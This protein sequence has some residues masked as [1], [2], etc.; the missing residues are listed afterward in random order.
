MNKPLVMEL[1]NTSF[2][3]AVTTYVLILFFKM[4]DHAT[5]RNPGFISLGFA[6]GFIAMGLIRIKRMLNLDYDNS[7]I[8]TLQKKIAKTKVLVL[9]FRKTEYL[10]LP[11]YTITV[12]PILLKG[13]LDQNIYSML[14]DT[15]M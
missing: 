12:A 15:Y 9:K 7:S 11:F 5:F 14:Q 3:F 2:L 1:L 4:F 6:I 13:L 8:V 10:M